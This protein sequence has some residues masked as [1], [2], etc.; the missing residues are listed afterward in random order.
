MDKAVEF[1]R[2]VADIR[3]I[4]QGIFDKQER[5]VVLDFVSDVEDLV[6]KTRLAGLLGARGA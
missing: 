1:E 6:G 3:Q 2:R 4:A 5:K